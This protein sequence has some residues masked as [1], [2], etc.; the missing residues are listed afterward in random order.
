MSDA[1]HET[2]LPIGRVET[3]DREL[4]QIAQ[5]YLSQADGDAVAALL[6]AIADGRAVSALVSRGFARLGQPEH[7]V[8]GRGQPR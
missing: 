1:G 6:Q 7:R 8:S 2:A 5:A 4:D 3:G